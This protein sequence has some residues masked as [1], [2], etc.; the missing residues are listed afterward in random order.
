MADDGQARTT[1][2]TVLSIVGTRPEAVKMAPVIRALA[3]Q[4]GIRSLVCATAQH[5]EMLDQVFDL[6]AIRPDVDLNLMQPNQTLPALT[7]LALTRV[8]QVLQDLQ[9]DL[10]LAQGDTTTVMVAGLASFYAQIPMGHVEAGLRTHRRYSPFPEEMN[11]RLV[12][13]LASLHFAPTSRAVAA[14]QAEGVSAEDIFLTGNTV[15]DAL[16]SIATQPFEPDPALRT[17]LEQTPGRLLLVTAHRRENFGAPFVAICLALRQIVERNPDVTLVYPVHLNP[18]VREPVMRILAGHE[19]IHLLEPVEYR[20]L[21]YLLKRCWLVLTD[22]GGIQEE[23]PVLGKPV[24]VL[25]RD[26][27]RPEGIEAGNARLVGTEQ[28]DIVRA[29]ERLLHDESAYQAMAQAA[30][31]YGDGRAARRIVDAIVAR[32]VN[33]ER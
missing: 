13:S 33:S 12:A 16:Q 31:P 18:Q 20:T 10:V 24:L 4:A 21:V 8:S 11:R 17:R 3:Q 1:P 23:A 7:A 22:S 19:R 6:F 29:T 2:F 26:T 14:L 27:E 28:A 5:R 30:S 9:P 25:R 15:V 32:Y